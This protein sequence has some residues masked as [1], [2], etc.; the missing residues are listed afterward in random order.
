MRWVDISVKNKFYVIFCAGITTFLATMGLLLYCLGGV[1]KDAE[2]L[3]LPPKTGALL[4][5]EVSHLHWAVSVQNY[6]LYRGDKPLTVPTEATECA[7]GKWFYGAQRR[8]LEKE[9]PAL[10]S[11]F[12]KIE[13]VHT[14]LHD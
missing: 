14:R 4:A 5:A 13:T 10:T 3:S 6:L 8:E 2:L 7:F 12:G 9:I 1:K 11:L